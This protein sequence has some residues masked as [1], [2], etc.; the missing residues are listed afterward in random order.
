MHEGHHYHERSAPSDSPEMRK[1]MLEYLLGHNRSHT[2]EL[3]DIGRKLE[4][5]GNIKA[6]EAVRESVSYF[7]QGSD[8]LERA[9]G[10]LEDN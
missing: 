6:A 1:A 2:R 7:K 10:L 8:A 5:T 3:E 9:A 4:S